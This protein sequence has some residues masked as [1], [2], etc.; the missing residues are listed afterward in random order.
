MVYTCKQD[1]QLVPKVSH[2]VIFQHVVCLEVSKVHKV[3]LEMQEV[4]DLQVRR[5]LKD[6][7]ETKEVRDQ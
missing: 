6:K 2:L 1:Y 7:Q 5:D 4:R 3:Q